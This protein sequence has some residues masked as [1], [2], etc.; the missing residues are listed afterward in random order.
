[1]TIGIDA[2][3]II[4]DKS[5]IGKY[6]FNLIKSILNIDTTNNYVLFFNSVKDVKK[7]SQ[8][9][10]DLTAN[11]K[12]AFEIQR[13]FL[14][15]NFRDY[16][17][18]FPINTKLFYPR[19]LDLM[20]F[21][22]YSGIPVKPIIPSIAT[23]HDVTFLKLPEIYTKKTQNIPLKKTQMALENCTKIIATSINTKKD[24]V[25]SLQ[26]D[27][28]KI[29]VI[30]EGVADTY[31]LLK[32]PIL[33]NKLRL[34]QLK[35]KQYILAIASVEPTKNLAK[36]I[37]AYALLP[38]L[39]RQQY[40]LVLIGKISG[41]SQLQTLIYDLNLS[42]QIVTLGTLLEKDMPTVFSGA[43]LFVSVSLYEGFSSSIIEAMAC[44]IP[45]VASNKAAI[46]EV[47]SQEILTA[48]PYKEEE[49]VRA[50]QNL[51]ESEELAATY[52]KKSL[53]QARKYSWARAG[54]ET[55]RFYEK[56]FQTHIE[57]NNKKY[58]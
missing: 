10:A 5:G 49:I 58:Q 14:P 45:V 38:H 3:S 37:K 34:F 50:I 16:L 2:N 21:P 27:P 26:A 9:I 41:K 53:H 25:G 43:K 19:S 57:N 28:T 42:K 23:L 54:A 47:T 31:R 20:H 18:N 36:L 12:A 13:S 22:F 30:D 8:L 46:A 52:E 15:L 32:K 17:T 44:G 7:Q 48:N 4:Y 35:Y 40:P 51:L 24:L 1:M 55:I 39:L 33:I 29:Q 56:T 6:T 11:A